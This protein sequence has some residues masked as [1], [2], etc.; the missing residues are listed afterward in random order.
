MVDENIFRKRIN[1][2]GNLSQLIAKV[3]DDYQLGALLNY[4]IITIGYEDL[5]IAVH[6]QNSR[7]LIKIFGEFRDYQNCLRYVD[8]MCKIVAHGIA[9][10]KL[11]PCQ[12]SYL[13]QYSIGKN[14]VYLCVMDYIDGHSFYDLNLRPTNGQAITLIREAAK[15][16]SLDF[17][18]E[19]YYDEWSPVNFLNEYQLKNKYLSYTDKHYIQKLLDPFSNIS[20]NTL[21]HGLVHGDIIRPNVILDSKSQ[22][23]IIDFSVAALKPRLQELSVLLCGMFFNEENPSDFLGFYNLVIQTYQPALS[24]EE[25]HILPLFTKVVFAMY[26]MMGKYSHKA[27]ALTTPENDYWIRLG[28]IGLEYCDELWK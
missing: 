4:K 26:V 17:Q 11:Y 14:A 12:N 6:T 7:Y 21:S 22:L 24:P 19:D 2:T 1:F 8:I 16:N 9:H 27:K 25:I 3:V 13:Y 10:P 18:P 23:Y 5:N 28:Q 20:L 15:I